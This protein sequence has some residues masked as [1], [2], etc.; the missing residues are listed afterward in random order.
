MP[1]NL[2]AFRT[3]PVASERQAG[4][5]G[6]YVHWPFCASKCPYCDFNSHVRAAV[7]DAIWRQALIAEIDYL[8]ARYF[9]AAERPEVGSI[10]FGGGTPSRMAPD[11]VAAVIERIGTHFPLARDVEITLEANPTSTE[12][13]KLKAFRA[14]GVNRLSLGVQA[15][16]DQALRFLGREHDA[17]EALA[18]L[19]L[20]QANF[21]RV[22]LDLIYAYPGQTVANW[23]EELSRALDLG[24]AHV[25][26]YQLTIEENTGFHGAVKRGAFTPMVE[27]HQAVLYELT[28]EL[29][30]QQGLPAYE[31]SNHAR[32]GE[33]CRHNLV[34]WRSGAYLGIGPGAH[35]RIIAGHAR[36][37]SQQVRNPE[38]WLAQI[39]R[40]G[41]GTLSVMPLT[42]AETVQEFLMMGLR[43][44]EGVALSRLRAIAG[45]A[46]ALD[47]NAL[48]KLQAAGF[49]MLR[50]NRLSVTSLGRPVLNR[51]LT[52]LL[53]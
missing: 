43:L 11:T 50:D 34:Y 10:F 40:E 35:G 12:A 23:R 9:T 49:L 36:L 20:A 30:E 45:D 2:A 37:A 6:V 3:A 41:H 18:A 47:P 28:Q 21:A 25:S 26:L 27:D 1:D 39:A 33:A 15:L 53:V 14:A 48:S 51:I 17:K 16:D 38:A 42:P 22:S 29:T 32:P 13:A 46:S 8:T 19:D 4:G 7:D 44:A 31:I 5:F 52:E 24:L